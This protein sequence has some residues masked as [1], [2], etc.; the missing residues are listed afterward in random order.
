MPKSSIT[1]LSR[2]QTILHLSSFSFFLNIFITLIFVTS[3]IVLNKKMGNSLK[4]DAN[5]FVAFFFFA[6]VPTYDTY[7]FTWDQNIIFSIRNVKHKNSSDAKHNDGAIFFHSHL[8]LIFGFFN[9]HYSSPS[10]R[11]SK[12]NNKRASHVYNSF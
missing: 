8:H 6:Y 1:H 5:H 4:F 11:D 9:I 2:L 7:M 12:I 3:L 10:S